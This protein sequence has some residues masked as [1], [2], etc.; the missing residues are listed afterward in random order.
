[1]ALLVYLDLSAIVLLLGA[2]VSALPVPGA[3]GA[4]N[5]EILERASG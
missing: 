3:A 2:Q 4:R 1:M 5:G